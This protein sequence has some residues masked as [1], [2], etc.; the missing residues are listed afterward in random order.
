MSDLL[1]GKTALITGG[2]SGI[3]EA[4]ARLFVSQGAN[5]VI[6]DVQQDRGDALS[7][8]LGDAARFVG[9]NIIAEDEWKA[10]VSFANSE[11]QSVDI[12]FNNAG[13][14]DLGPIAE[15]SVEAY[16]RIIRVNQIGTFLGIKTAAESMKATG[17]GVIINTASAAALR[18]NPGLFIYS[19][20]KAAICSMTKTAAAELGA[21]GIRVNAV[22][23]GSIDTAMTNAQATGPHAE[24]RKEFYKT[25]PVPRQGAAEDIA[26]A[27][28]FL[29]SDMGSYCTGVEL[30][31]DGGL[32]LPM[33]TPPRKD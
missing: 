7:D 11:F 17:G 2:S 24:A 31:V 4:A 1:G 5:V 20:T 9:L 26:S 29:A 23:P 27:A 15:T 3:G 28:F 8:E 18:A 13:I 10:A 22:L 30:V 16:E 14:F 6:A 25:L 19:A 32:T 33:A 12:L 21:Y